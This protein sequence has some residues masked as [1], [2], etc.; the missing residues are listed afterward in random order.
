MIKLNNVVTG[1]PLNKHMSSLTGLKFVFIFLSIN[2]LSRRDKISVAVYTI[3]KTKSR[4]G[5]NRKTSQEL[6]PTS[7][8]P[9]DSAESDDLLLIRE[10]LI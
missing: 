9:A 6:F 1:V 4:T 2:I 8:S 3:I 7:Q 5:R 10:G